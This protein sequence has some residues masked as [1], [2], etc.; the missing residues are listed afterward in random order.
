MYSWP[1]AAPACP[2]CI[3]SQA[4]RVTLTKP[5]YTTAG[6]VVRACERKGKHYFDSKEWLLAGEIPVAPHIRTNL[7]AVDLC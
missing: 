2:I 1:D 5:S 3:Q 4:E 6:R 7:Y